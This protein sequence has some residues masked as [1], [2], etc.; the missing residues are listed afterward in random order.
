MSISRIRSRYEAG[1]DRSGVFFKTC[2]RYG[3]KRT[4][5]LNISI[6]IHIKTH[7]AFFNAQEFVSCPT[8]DRIFYSYFNFKNILLLTFNKYFCN[9]HNNEC[10]YIKCKLWILICVYLIYTWKPLLNQLISIFS[11]ILQGNH[12]HFEL[13]TKMKTRSD[14]MDIFILLHALQPS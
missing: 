10:L 7:F 13:L 11:I 9:N 8:N 12:N 1:L 5:V 4:Q 6:Y 14:I 2:I 3:A